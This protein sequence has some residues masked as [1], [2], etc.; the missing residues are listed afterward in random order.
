MKIIDSG[1]A[2]VTGAPSDVELALYSKRTGDGGRLMFVQFVSPPQERDRDSLVTISQRDE[3]EGIRYVQSNDSFLT[4]KGVTSEDALFGMTIQEIAD[5]QPEKYDFALAGEQSVGNRPVYKIDGKLK[6][7][8]ESKFPRLVLLI[9][10]D[11]YAAVGAEFYDNHNQVARRVT[12]EEI[13]QV[14]G[15]WT[16]M[17]WTLDNAARGKRLEFQTI[18]ARYQNV[19]D[20]IFTREHLKKVATK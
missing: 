7:G 5:G 4:T 1:T 9:A 2:A 15:Q 12:V 3:V 14:E 8:A 13:K 11:N 10:K 17:R 19:N 18:E 6:A 20:S 16:R